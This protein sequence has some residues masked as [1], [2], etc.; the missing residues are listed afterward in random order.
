MVK[1]GAGANAI[2]FKWNFKD[3][4]VVVKIFFPGVHFPRSLENFKC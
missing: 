1:K 3:M 4:D 2:V